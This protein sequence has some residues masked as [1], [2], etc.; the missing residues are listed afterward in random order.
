MTRSDI[1]RMA[2]EAGLVDTAS[3]P[4]LM[5][6]LGRFAKLVA[7][8]EREECA[9]DCEGLSGRSYEFDMGRLHCAAAIRARGK[10]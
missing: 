2:E 3:A 6:F 10:E 7:E 9:K 4:W 1:I 8:A 5:A